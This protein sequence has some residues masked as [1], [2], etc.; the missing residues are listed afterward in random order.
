MIHNDSMYANKYRPMPD[1]NVFINLLL[2]V[3][4]LGLMAIMCSAYLL[5]WLKAKLHLYLASNIKMILPRPKV[6]LLNFDTF[7]LQNVCR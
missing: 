7:L 3:C 5:S 2:T 1:G 4:V 6:V